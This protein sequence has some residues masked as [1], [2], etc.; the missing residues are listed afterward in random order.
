MGA[1]VNMCNYIFHL[2]NNHIE[3]LTQTF[4]LLAIIFEERDKSNSRLAV[5]QAQNF[6]WLIN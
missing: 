4:Q 5:S 3:R 1:T 6:E 2:P